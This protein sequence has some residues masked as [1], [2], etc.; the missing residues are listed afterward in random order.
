M[1]EALLLLSKE[2]KEGGDL[3]VVILERKYALY[4]EEGEDGLVQAGCTDREISE[5]MGNTAKLSLLQTY[6][7]EYGYTQQF[8]NEKFVLYEGGIR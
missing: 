4:L 3:P 5:V 6:M 1:E 7:E 8:A 2:I